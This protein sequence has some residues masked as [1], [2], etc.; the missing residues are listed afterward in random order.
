MFSTP[1]QKPPQMPVEYAAQ[2]QPDMGAG[3][4]AGQKARDRM[5]AAAGTVLTGS[6]AGT[7]AATTQKKTLLGS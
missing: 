7:G 5:R 3:L 4:S 1:K 2:K 6:A